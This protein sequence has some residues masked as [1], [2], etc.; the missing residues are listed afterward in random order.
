MQGQEMTD[1]P[2]QTE[3]ANVPSPALLFY[4]DPPAGSQLNSCV[5]LSDF[6]IYFLTL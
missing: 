4:S 3:K 2:A 6:I 1:V 5:F